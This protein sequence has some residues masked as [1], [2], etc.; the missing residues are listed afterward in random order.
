MS[1]TRIQHPAGTARPLLSGGYAVD[2]G[3][4]FAT[5]V[6]DREHA[7]D[8]LDSRTTKTTAMRRDRGG[9]GPAWEAAGPTHGHP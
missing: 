1:A 3:D 6:P 8:L 4:T 5:W 7:W 9:V 2:L